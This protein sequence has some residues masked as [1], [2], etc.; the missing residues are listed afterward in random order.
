MSDVIFKKPDGS[1][2]KVD[3]SEAAQAQ[4]L[5]YE[6]SSPEQVK[7]SKQTVRAA[8][9][10]AARGL[11]FG[12]S[13]PFLTAFGA[14]R[15]EVKA[16]REENR[17]VSGTLEFAGVVGPALLTGGVSGM[18]GG[19]FRG[20]FVEGG[21]MG[22]GGMVSESALEN[23]PL[24]AER[25]AA[26]LVGGG[27]A[28]GAAHTGF[29]LIGKGVSAGVKKFAGSG[30][31][32]A[33]RE[34]ALKVE[35]RALAEGASGAIDKLKKRGGSIRDV[36]EYAKKE[37][38]PI[39]FTDDALGK[40]KA[41][42]AK[43]GQDTAELL[44]RANKVKPLSNAY[45]RKLL[46]SQVEDSVKAAFKGDIAAEE[47]VAK[48][49]EKELTPLYTR[50]DLSYGQLYKLQSRL[51]E[52][53]ASASENQIKRQ[54]YNT[55]RKALRDRLFED[56]GAVNPGVQARLH[57][58]QADY[59]KG[60]FLSEAIEKRMARLEATGGVPGIGIM[61]VLRGGGF[62][63]SAG[64]AL[65]GPAGAPLGA[66]A[67][68]YANKLMR[69][70]GG[71]LAANAMRAIADGKLT[72]G[73]SKNLSNRINQVL[74]VA[75][76]MLGAYR[77]PLAIAAAKGTDALLEEH[78]RQASAPTGHDYM[79]RL[80]LSVETPE[81]VQA[82]GHKM[83][84]LDA[85]Q[86]ATVAQDVET[87]KA[88]DGI[89]GSSPGRK[90]THSQSV[91]T[92]KQFKAFQEANQAKLRNPEKA[93]EQIP[94]ELMAVA[95]GTMSAAASK[96]MEIAKYLDSKAPKNPYAGMPE[97]VAPRWEPS[98]ADLDRF[99]RC[100][101]AVENP[102][103]VLK[104]LANGYMSPEQIDAIRAVYPT[105]YQDLR[106]KLGERLAMSK[107][108]LTYHQKTAAMAIL[109][110][111]ALG[112]SQQQMQILQQSHQQASAPPG[113]GGMKK[114][115][116]R[117]DVDQEKNLQTQSQRLEAR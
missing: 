90:G 68:A 51:R 76:A 62:G 8:L 108:P 113:G 106:E 105:I 65:L 18:V 39:A 93:F 75:P 27:L 47:H 69:E 115:D 74:S 37:N 20:A 114:P 109:G 6:P 107:K 99:N 44:E 81:E 4:E 88:I 41:A 91:L 38:I 35:E 36:V 34:Q 17:G 55:G 82:A 11:T 33:L 98:A 54:V 53:V 77:Y 7:A 61:D 29:G 3:S 84:V 30:V 102:A 14:D 66:M 86:A 96:A 58:L 67:G 21:L 26:G 79:A 22:L 95:P 12:F 72:E 70:R 116:G 73:I 101:E 103:K 89:L 87:S 52:E 78:I 111:G 46:V 23:S 25:V 64:A 104:N 100:K 50:E 9:E 60:A 15:K 112:M 1:F 5:G 85:I 43:T 45:N 19:G 92:A 13:D 16:R 48:F 59:A 49:L 57:G 32:N 2:V 56:A 94:S 71:S 110:P 83:A 40:A 63:A 28:S 31:G 97:S 80:G 42:V 10:G 24:T 117:Q